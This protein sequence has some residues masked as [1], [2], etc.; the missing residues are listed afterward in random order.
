MSVYIS[1]PKGVIGN[2]SLRGGEGAET[3]LSAQAGFRSIFLKLEQK[4]EITNLSLAAPK[5]VFYKD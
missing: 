4:A 1:W 3:T 5:F 2:G